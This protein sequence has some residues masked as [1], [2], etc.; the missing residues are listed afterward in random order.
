[1][2][3]VKILCRSNMFENPTFVGPSHQKGEYKKYFS[4]LKVTSPSGILFESM[5]QTF[6]LWEMYVASERESNSY[7]IYF[8]KWFLDVYE[9]YILYIYIYIIQ[10]FQKWMISGRCA[11]YS[12]PSFW[13]EIYMVLRT[14]SDLPTSPCSVPS[15]RTWTIGSWKTAV[16]GWFCVS[17]CCF[18]GEK[19]PMNVMNVPVLGGFSKITSS[20]GKRKEII[21][22]NN[23]FFCY[24]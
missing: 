18:V 15:R 13:G 20:C 5:I 16:T 21:L 14:L 1:M 11:S 17:V 23:L 9:W 10:I 2:I 22:R 19:K 7:Q 4:T 12:K 8:L 6:F 24:V 3:T